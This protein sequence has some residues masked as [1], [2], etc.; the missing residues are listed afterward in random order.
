MH[1][2]LLEA[3]LL[4]TMIVPMMLQS[5]RKGDH[6]NDHHN[7]PA[8]AHTADVLDKWMSMQLRLLKNATGTPNQGFARHVAYSG[9]TAVE[10]IAPGLQASERSLRNWNGLSGLPVIDKKMKYFHPATVNAGMAAINRSFFPNA[11][12][13]DKKA[14][15]SL[16]AKLYADFV[17]TT[18][19]SRLIASV[20]FGKD[21]AKAVFDWSETDGYKNANAPYTP[22]VG[23]GLWVPTPPALAAAST[24]YFGNDRTIVAG[25][26]KGA[27][28]PAP[29]PYSTKPGTEF[30][31]MVK[32]VYDASL[33]LTDDQKAMSLFWRDIP[34]VTSPGHWLSIVQQVSKKIQVR[35]DKAALAYALVG[36]GMNDG[37][38][39]TFK[40][41]YQ[42]TLVRPITYIQ[43][44]MG[45]KN[46][47]SFIGTPAHPE[48]VSAHSSLSA[49]SAVV[50]Q[51]LYGNVGTITDHTYDYMGMGARTYSSF[52][53]I[54]EE[55][56]K[57]RLYGGIHYQNSIDAGLKQGKIVAQNI[58]GNK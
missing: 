17:S 38:I 30:H 18:D 52:M 39:A 11:S 53:A 16:E 33:T 22:P 14:I 1:K 47:L 19:A 32:E 26:T 41:K 58:L 44:V 56:G 2:H 20:K 55:A 37:L 21:V 35:L 8:S 27:Q 5:C 31:S 57:S 4:L 12:A 45:N 23:D 46:W 51:Q 28:M 48:Y 49:A 3:I 43:N 40:D 50:L 24:P 29:P 13:D 42:Y 9:I 25:S 54:A 10:S 7:N 6:P 36:A 15:D 34:G